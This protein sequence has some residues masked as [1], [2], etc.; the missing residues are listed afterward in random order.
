MLPILKQ[1]AEYPK[2]KVGTDVDKLVV[3]KD[4][5]ADSPVLAELPTG[6]IVQQI[7]EA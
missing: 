2:W 5:G 3:N 7:G 6:T 1:Q 4:I